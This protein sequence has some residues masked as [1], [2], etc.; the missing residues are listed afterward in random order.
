[1]KMRKRRIHFGLLL[2]PWKRDPDAKL[3][4]LSVYYM[5]HRKA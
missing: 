3:I 2:G 5:V 1:M 4:L